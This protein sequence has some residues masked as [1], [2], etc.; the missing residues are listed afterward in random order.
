MSMGGPVERSKSPGGEEWP[1]AMTTEEA[2]KELAGRKVT[3]NKEEKSKGGLKRERDGESLPTEKEGPPKIQAVDPANRSPSVA[4]THQVAALLGIILKGDTKSVILDNLN[5]DELLKFGKTNHEYA[6]LALQKIS[7]RHPTIVEGLAI[8]DPLSIFKATKRYDLE[9]E[10]GKAVLLQTL[11]ENHSP[12]VKCETLEE[13]L[14]N[15]TA[16][17]GVKY[18]LVN[19]TE[20]PMRL[21]AEIARLPNLSHI[22]AASCQITEL[23]SAIAECSKLEELSMEANLLTEL[24][25]EIG[26]CSQIKRLDVLYNYLSSLPAEIGGC[27]DLSF[28]NCGGNRLKTLPEELGKCVML[29]TINAA[30]NCLEELPATLGNCYMLEELYL[31]YN[32]LTE[33]PPQIGQCA[34]LQTV[35]LSNNRLRQ[36]PPELGDLNALSALYITNNC[37]PSL[38]E[39][40]RC[41]Q[42]I[43][44]HLSNNDLR[45]IPA[46]ISQ[47]NNLS[48]LC[49]DGNE[50]TTLPE[51]P[52]LGE[53][54]ISSKNLGVDSCNTLI[55]TIPRVKENIE[56]MAKSAPWQPPTIDVDTLKAR[57]VSEE[58]A[59]R[60]LVVSFSKMTTE[61]VL[62]LGQV[63]A[64]QADVVI[65]EIKKRHPS[66]LDNVQ[67]TGVGAVLIASENYRLELE[68]GRRVL[69]QALV[70]AYPKFRDC[71]TLDEVMKKKDEVLDVRELNLEN[72]MGL[73]IRLPPEIGTFSNLT[74]LN[75]QYCRITELPAA[76]GECKKLLTLFAVGNQLTKLPPEIGNCSA[77]ISLGLS[78]NYLTEL[79]H[80]LGQCASLQSLNC[81]K[82]SLKR[83]PEE[84]G[85]CTALQTLWVSDNCLKELPTTLGKC[86]N[87][88]ELKVDSNYLDDIPSQLGACR[89]LELLSLNNNRLTEIPP[90]LCSC[91]ALQKADFSNN[92]L[93]SLPP[94]IEQ[95]EYL[96]ELNVQNNEL[97]SLPRQLGLL[98]KL[99][100]LEAFGNRLIKLP[101][102]IVDLLSLTGLTIAF[103]NLDR[104]HLASL[105][106][107]G[108]TVAE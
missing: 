78:N 51:L 62:H 7:R 40:G 44:L 54:I 8:N 10:R 52:P 39:L 24:P 22:F 91:T 28:L 41:K 4:A 2:P 21:P 25:R 97:E 56:A 38:P 18:L 101:Q 86:I 45:S 94:E 15:A 16:V 75:I 27:K 46:W 43:A 88:L 55:A 32:Y 19:K 58:E 70:K 33:I 57:A 64:I 74:N 23:P 47:C 26:N 76:I 37:L 80:E 42:L 99:H 1:I 72:D 108:R 71:A 81:K 53:L 14:Q 29:R 83:L 87:L 20:L 100:R 92:R 35:N 48:L 84:L 17:E 63:N 36:L 65:D 104:R 95:L 85:N 96:K 82:N 102:E 66:I 13:A 68:R 89:A 103:K 3:H 93:R 6:L 77:L 61:E 31:Q 73:P 30:G 67:R 11:K 34:H 98:N 105:S 90:A 12:F 50:I 60:R 9:L 79:P 49:V 69:L 5:I 106:R 107:N 59:N